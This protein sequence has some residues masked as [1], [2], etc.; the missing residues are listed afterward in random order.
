MDAHT[1]QK[2]DPFEIALLCHAGHQAIFRLSPF[3]DKKFQNWS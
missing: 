3:A 1:E 2:P